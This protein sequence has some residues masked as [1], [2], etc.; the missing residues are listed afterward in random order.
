MIPNKKPR[1]LKTLGTGVGAEFGISRGDE[2]H[3]MVILRDT[4]YSDKVLA[5]IR[6]YSTNAW[7]EHRESGRKDMP[8]KIT[9]PTPEDPTFSVRD[10]GRGLSEDDVL[11][12][13][14]QYGASTKRESDNSV[15][16][17]GIGSKSAFAYS[18]SFT[19]T[20]FFNGEKSMY[21]AVLT[22]D[23]KGRI[24]LLQRIPTKEQTGVLIQIA[25]RQ[26]DIWEFKQKAQKFFMYFQPRPDINTQI[27]KL[28]TVQANLKN[29]V[30]YDLPK[31]YGTGDGW[32]AIMG[33]VSYHIDLKQL[34]AAKVIEGDEGSDEDDEDG[35]GTKKQIVLDEEDKLPAYVRNISGALY[36]DIGEV[37]INASREELKYSDDTKKLLKT[38]IFSV[39]DEYV[40]NTL[41]GIKNGGF[42]RWEQRVQAQ[43]LHD[44]ELPVSKEC[45]E[46]LVSHID[47]E[48]AEFLKKMPKSLEIFSDQLGKRF[49]RRIEIDAS[50][51]FILK[52]DTRNINGFSLNGY[53]YLVRKVGKKNSDTWDIVVKDLEEFIGFMDLKGVPVIS[54]STVPWTERHRYTGK[55]INPK[56]H[57]KVFKLKGGFHE[58]SVR[59]NNW[60]S[61][62]HVPTPEDV[63]VVMAYFETDVVDRTFDLYRLYKLDEEMAE[64][65]GGKMPPIIGYKSTE[66]KKVEPK[67]CIGKYYPEWRKEFAK[68]LLNPKT[69]KMLQFWGWGRLHDEL[70]RL[71]YNKRLDGSGYKLLMKELGSKHPVTRMARNYFRALQFF[72]KDK[73]YQAIDQIEHMYELVKEGI[74]P[75]EADRDLAA[76]QKQYPLM[77]IEDF[78]LAKLWGKDAPQ[79]VQYIKTMDQHAAKIEEANA[80]TAVHDDQRVDHGDPPGEAPR[81]AEGGTPVQRLDEGACGTGL[82]ECAQPP[83][84]GQELGGVGQ[85][86]VHV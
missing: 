31:S 18:D 40:Q 59:S 11:K 29:G 46:L 70:Q 47:L 69:M 22:K 12:V 50:T 63:F 10:Y 84:G 56:H 60:E 27:P 39:V 37:T 62:K 51:R 45:K 48:G 73:H 74:E 33:C 7:D 55:Q 75:L 80:G 24:D 61:I 83:D 53:D 35:K 13:Y 28:P 77:T 76:V 68:S 4:L 19:I 38:K 64:E 30:I 6:E 8:I 1:V 15:G 54:L 57:Q 58:R 20:S 2:A 41:D 65:F 16:F 14:S 79:W 23:E 78:E 44:L 66:K 52:D 71:A 43:V 25:V 26:E 34:T 82:G 3:I 85:G 21:V 67:D 32:I 42:S 49:A 9:L 81:G 17:L 72:K 5:V 86:Q 36:F